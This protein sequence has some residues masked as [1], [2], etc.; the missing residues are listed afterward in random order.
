[1]DFNTQMVWIVIY[2]FLQE[3][4]QS[5]ILLKTLSYLKEY[6]LRL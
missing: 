6:E 4:M 5:L 2:K 3:E 1:M